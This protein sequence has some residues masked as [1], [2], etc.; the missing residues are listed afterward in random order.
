MLNE[1]FTRFGTEGE[2]FLNALG[3]LILVLASL[4]ILFLPR[5]HVVAPLLI[6]GLLLPLSQMVVVGGLHFML[7][8]ILILVAWIRIA[9]GMP[10]S[11]RMRFNTIDWMVVFW[12]LSTIVAFT[13]LWG[14]AEALLN[15]MGVVYNAFGTYF[16]FRCLYRDEQDIRR[17]I[18]TFA[19]I[20][21]ILGGF[22]LYEHLTGYNCF[23]ILGGAREFSEVREAQVRAQGPFAHSILAGTFGAIL[24]PLFAG[25]WWQGK[26]RIVAA[27]GMIAATLI[28]L[29]SVS[30]TAIMAYFAGVAALFLW[31]LR[32]TMRWLRWSILIALLSLHL[33]MKAPVWALIARIDL[34]GGSSG[35]HRYELIDQ[36]I[37]HFSDWWLLGQKSTYQWGYDQWDTSNAYV[38]TAVTGGLLTLTVFIAILTY[39]FK[40]LGRTWRRSPATDTAKMTWALGAWLF[41]NVT[42]FFGITYF[43]QTMIAWYG[44]LA[45]ISTIVGLPRLAQPAF[46]LSDS[47]PAPDDP[48]A[49]FTT[50]ISPSPSS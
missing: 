45:M 20:S 3:M 21:V 2:T 38:E 22:M 12:G 17:T 25:L 28:T 4:L 10:Q 6:A 1:T 5:K 32:A 23:S 27:A 8:R 36:C 42:A 29:T 39:C 37:R 26:S 16:L 40:A 50:T 30:S 19:A 44:I 7:V 15:R 14:S 9:V 43:D 18:E 33:V 48:W 35:Y 31:P 13:L 11:I 34:V 46:A 49:A 24:L 41:A 47:Q